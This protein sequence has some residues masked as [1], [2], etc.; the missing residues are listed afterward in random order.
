[1]QKASLSLV[2]V[3][4]I[5]LSEADTA[6]GFIWVFISILGTASEREY[7][8]LSAAEQAVEILS[9]DF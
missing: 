2:W 1:M 7:N 5:E 8:M 9:A 3:I 6:P 4:S